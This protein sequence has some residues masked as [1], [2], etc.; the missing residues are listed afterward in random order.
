MKQN[1]IEWLQSDNK[2]HENRRHA[3][4]LII[5]ALS[6]NA[7]TLLYPLINQILENL[8]LP[9]RDH[10]IIVREDAAV[11]LNKCMNIIND[12]DVNARTFW[13]KR[14]IDLA[15]KL[16]NENDVTETSDSNS[17]YNIALSGQSSENIHGSLLIYRELLT[18]YKDPFIV[19]RFEQTYE[20][21][22]LYK[23]HKLH[24]IRQE[25][26][27]I[28]PL[29]C[30][31]NTELFVEKY[32]HRTLYYYLSQLKKYK[33]QHTEVAN[34][35]KALFSKVLDSSLWKWVTKWLHI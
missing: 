16:L 6:D 21:T 5:T 24:I 34:A 2:Q 25:L 14:M 29:L 31:V 13:I 27:N 1:E 12:R 11:A 30:R 28:F 22:Y 9:L 4:I 17:S 10:K 20:N 32:L 23:H 26:T 33:G 35:I 19:S 3:A 8:W 18:Y 7:P 15:S